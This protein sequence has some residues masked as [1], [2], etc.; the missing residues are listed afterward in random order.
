MPRIKWWRRD[1]RVLW[2]FDISFVVDMNYLLNKQLSYRG[3]KT[4]WDSCNVIYTQLTFWC[5]CCVFICGFE[6]NYMQLPHCIK[7]VA[8]FHN[9]GEE[10]TLKNYANSLQWRH[11][12]RD[13]VS[14]HQ[15]HHCSLNRLF[16]RRSEKTSKLRV[17]G[18]CAGNSPATGEFPAQ[19]AR[20]ADMFPFD[21]VILWQEMTLSPL[22]YNTHIHK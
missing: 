8:W 12:G 17:T 10:E 2:R 9:A 5:H 4:P 19:R 16:R 20:N 18:L 22:G 3:L 15:A 13:G 1:R 7:E 14:N 21:D 6:L 11:N